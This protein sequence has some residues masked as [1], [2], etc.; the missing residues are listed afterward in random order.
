M[1]KFSL[2][3]L[4]VC[5]IIA[6]AMPAAAV[7]VKFS[8][9][10]YA[11]G[12]YVDN[13]SVLDKSETP[14]APSWTNNSRRSANAFYSQRFRLQT[15]FQVVEGLKLVTRLDALEKR[16]GDQAWAGG[17]GETQSRTSVWA[18]TANQAK[19]QENL[20]FERAYLDFNVSFG[21]FQVGYM[22]YLVWGT[23]FLNSTLTAP[24]VRYL[25]NQGPW[26]AIAAVEKRTEQLGLTG[27]KLGAT[28][29]SATTGGSGYI[30]QGNDADRDVYDL[31]GIYKFKAGEA[32]LLYQ[33]I[34]SSQFKTQ[35]N[36]GYLT[37]LSGFYPY[38]KLT[39]GKLFLE[40][41][42]MYGFGDL[43]SYENNGGVTNASQPTAGVNLNK[44]QNVSLTALGAYAHAKYDLKPAYMGA[45]FVYIS[46]DDQSNSDKATGSILQ[47]LQMNRNFY[48]TLILWNDDYQNNMGNI[49]GN[50]PAG[51]TG[52]NRRTGQSYAV[53]QEMDNVW[54]YQVYAGVKPTPKM[55][56]M[57]ALSI[58][59][60]DKKPKSD[61]G[62][63]GSPGYY[64]GANVTEFV[65][66]Q[67]GTELDLT[68]SYKI[69]DNLTYM[70]GAG[71]LWTGDY[72]KGYDNSAVVSNNYLLSHKLTLTF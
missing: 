18:G 65:S 1:R 62:A 52:T 23:S 68:A 11:M 25:Y 45:K 16:W 7:D 42:F 14:G 10:Y 17:V 35:Y 54:F 40:G 34:R 20:E 41:E 48:P 2:L 27:G 56:V 50:T 22:E 12:W 49:Q 15:E 55:D 53:R 57:A 3:L 4:S 38:A 47:S 31:G 37:Q 6:F 30:G 60:A 28:G 21:K 26:Q 13:P 29:T 69:Y 70:I 59:S 39:F 58:A 32:G 64:G 63:V 8:G 43:R 61:V 19:I 24:G 71:Y 33:Y 46:G 36:N 67:Y 44:A 5:L 72:F 51:A 9:S 66:G